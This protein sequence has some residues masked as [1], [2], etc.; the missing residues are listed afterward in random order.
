[1]KKSTVIILII[2]SSCLISCNQNLSR[3][4]AKNLIVEKYKLPKDVIETFYVIDGTLGKRFSYDEYE[5][6]QKEGLLNFTYE[7]GSSTFYSELTEKGKQY[8]VSGV[9]DTDNMYIK[10]VNVKVASLDFGEITGIVE[11]KEYNMAEVSFTLVP[12]NVTPFGS[13]AFQYNGSAISQTATFI[14]YDD[15]WRIE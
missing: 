1:M 14:K 10:G 9:F 13:I 2:C 4:K 12:S 6:L 7:R 8:A 15:G 3:E 11:R 5:A